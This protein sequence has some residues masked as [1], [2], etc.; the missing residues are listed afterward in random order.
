MSP[1]IH[2]TTLAAAAA[3]ALT[4]GA[5]S[6][7][8]AQDHTPRVIA[9]YHFGAPNRTIAFPATIVV[10]D[11]AGTLVA[12]ARMAGEHGTLPLQVSVLDSDLVLQGETRDGTLTLVLGQQ[13]VSNAP[14]DADG[15]WSLGSAEGR[16]RTRR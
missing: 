13:A 16:L 9:T 4:A 12:N 5:A 11:S 10:A 1:T 15:R 3:V 8:D 14:R 6:A 7:Q 2:R